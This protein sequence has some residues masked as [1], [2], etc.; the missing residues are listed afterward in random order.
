MASLLK[1]DPSPCSLRCSLML[2]ARWSMTSKAIR[3]CQE[4]YL[5]PLRQL[6]RRMEQ[7]RWELRS[8][9]LMM[10]T[11]QIW[12]WWLMRSLNQ[13]WEIRGTG[14]WRI[15]YLL[16]NSKRCA[17]ISLRCWSEEMNHMMHRRRC[18][19]IRSSRERQTST[20][21]ILMR[22]QRWHHLR[23]WGITLWRR[24]QLIYHRSS[25]WAVMAL[26]LLS[27]KIFYLRVKQV[28]VPHLTSLMRQRGHPKAV[29]KSS[30]I[31][32]LRKVTVEISEWVI[33]QTFLTRL[34]LLRKSRN[35]AMS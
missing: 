12:T 8:V 26:R 25:I 20:R 29:T 7:I 35:R 27:I 24:S 15:S 14:A 6:Y 11:I 4:S 1:I 5:S 21:E 28:M 2:S 17:R 33:Q 10:T 23:G 30:R 3:S 18:W 13:I 19:G 9:N 22:Q 34:C 32:Q 16:L 31:S